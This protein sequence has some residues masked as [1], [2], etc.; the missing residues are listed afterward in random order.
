MGRSWAITAAVIVAALLFTVMVPVGEASASSETVVFSTDFEGVGFFISAWEPLGWSRGDYA[1]DHQDDLWCRVNTTAMETITQ[2]SGVPITAHSTQSALYGNRLGTNSANGANNLVNGYPDPGMDSWVRFAPPNAA[3]YDGMTLTFWYWAKTQAAD[4]TGELT[5]YLCVNI[6]DGKTTTR[7]W[8]QPSPDSNG[9]QQ[10]TVELPAGTAWMEWEFKTSTETVGHYPGVL[11]DDVKVTTTSPA[12]GS[13]T[14]QVGAM[15]PYYDHGDVFVPVT[16]SNADSLSLYYRTEGGSWT[17]YSD[18]A[19]PDGKLTAPV[20]FN[21]PSDGRYELFA[22]AGNE[23]MKNTAEASFIVDTTAPEVTITAPRHGA[24]YGS[25]ALS[26]AWSAEDPASGIARTEVSVDDGPWREASGTSYPLGTLADGEHGA[27]VKVTDRA[28]RASEVSVAFVVDST[29][30][31]MTVSPIGPGAR[32]DSSI[33]A[34]FQEAVDHDSVAIAVSGVSGD[35]SWSGEDAVF[36]PSTPLEPEKEYEVTVS[37]RKAGGQEFSV[38]WSFT[39]IANVG[40]IF[41]TVRGPEGSAVSDAKVMLSSGAST[42]TDS[43]GR[44]EFT[45]VAPGRYTLTVTA[46]GYEALTEEVEVLAG[47]NEELGV[48]NVAS[49][50]TGL[51]PPAIFDLALILVPLAALGIVAVAVL[52]RKGRRTK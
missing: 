48:L 18:K 7:A 33:I 17:M 47:E 50:R 44:F 45:G 6:Y 11:I 5:D 8:T 24:I 38:N 10:A 3:S 13:P 14:S 25:G 1:A 29:A 28:G 20:T 46:E 15:Y 42:T 27:K 2:G 12:A 31:A 37:G 21:A 51:V 32:L 9:W 35:L 4:F 26:L 49:A 16:V 30:P 34:S 52:R 41:G 39:T 43:S 22:L 36:A 23:P 40:N 19:H